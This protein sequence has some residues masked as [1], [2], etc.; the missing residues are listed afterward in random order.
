[1]Q[2]EGEPGAKNVPP[3]LSSE[4]MERQ[5]I[6]SLPL[7]ETFSSRPERPKVEVFAP[8]R[9]F[10]VQKGQGAASRPKSYPGCQQGTLQPKMSSSSLSFAWRST[11]EGKTLSSPLLSRKL[12]CFLKKFNW[13]SISQIE[14]YSWCR[15]Q[16]GSACYEVAVPTRSAVLVSNLAST[17]FGKGTVFLLKT[18]L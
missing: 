18:S 3:W 14:V 12:I 15:I 1:M 10:I 2:F 17:F 13:K 16:T 8:G 6:P 9:D 7:K 11:T 5:K 4:T